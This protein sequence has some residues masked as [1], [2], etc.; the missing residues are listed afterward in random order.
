M[1]P[2]EAKKYID[3]YVAE[4]L[5][6]FYQYSISNEAFET[7][8]VKDLIVVPDPHK[9]SEFECLGWKFIIKLEFYPQY[10]AAYLR[11]Y[12]IVLDHKNYPHNKLEHL[13]EMDIVIQFPL[14]AGVR[15]LRPYTR[16]GTVM[17]VEVDVNTATIV[18]F[19]KQYLQQL[20]TTLLIKKVPPPEP[21]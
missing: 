17:G 7:M 3:K 12:E 13:P 1:N 19:K 4:V 10:Q 9:L 5:S 11:T 18:N 8:P 14:N 16:S 21:K 20:Y 2:I 15:F 6:G